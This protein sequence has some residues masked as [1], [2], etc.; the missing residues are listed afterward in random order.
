MA[1]LIL[2]ITLP[3]GKKKTIRADE[4]KALFFGRDPQCDVQLN[5]PSVGPVHFRIRRAGAAWVMETATNATPV[6]LNGEPTQRAELLPGDQLRVGNVLIVVGEPEA[7]AQRPAAAAAARLA[8]PPADTFAAPPQA[9]PA[10]RPAAPIAPPSESILRS[11]LI[12]GSAVALVVLIG[13]G[14]YLYVW[15]YG[16]TSE[17]LFDQAQQAMNE[18][19]SVYARKL[20]ERFLEEY[21]D[22]EL[23]N[24][25]LIYRE[26]CDVQAAQNEGNPQEALREL[27]DLFERT[28]KLPEFSDMAAEVA[29]TAVRVALQL[30]EAAQTTGRR[31]DYEQARE[32]FNVLRE[33]VPED[34]QPEEQIQQLE[35]A[36][37]AAERAVIK[38]ERY[39][40][41]IATM[42]QALKDRDT[43]RAYR[44]RDELVVLYPDFQADEKLQEL[45]K[46]GQQLD[47]DR[48]R[49]ET[50]QLTP[51]REDRQ[52][53]AGVIAATPVAGAGQGPS[54]VGYQLA[55]G[56]LYAVST[57]DGKPLWRRS[58]GP[59]ARHLPVEL[60]SSVGARI[61]VLAPAHRELAVLDATSGKLQWRI[62]FDEPLDAP[63]IVHRDKL[64]LV[65][66]AGN[67]YRIDPGTGRVEGRL[68]FG[69]QELTVPPV[70]SVSGRH[71]YVVGEHSNVYIV[72]VTPRQ[73][74]AVGIF[75]L[76]HLKKTVHAAP[77]RMGRYLI[78]CENR[79]PRDCVLRVLL[80]AADERAFEELPQD[81]RL[82]GWVLS[83]PASYGNLIYV[84]TDRDTV[85]LFSAGAP[86]RKEGLKRLAA[87]RPSAV[88]EPSGPAYAVF[89][90]EE[91]LIVA[92]GTVRH[93]RVSLER[94][95]LRPTS[96]VDDIS[97]VTVQPVQKL[98]DQVFLIGWKANEDPAFRLT[99]VRFTGQTF[100]KLWE[101]RFALGTTALRS[102]G[103]SD[104]F[105]VT[106]TADLFRLTP[107]SDGVDFLM[108]PVGRV[109]LD[110]KVLRTAHAVRLPDGPVVYVPQWGATELYVRDDVDQTD[111]RRL[112]LPAGIACAPCGF[113]G[114][115]LLPATDQRVYLLDV[116]DGA[117]L[118]EPFQPPVQFDVERQW[119]LVLPI[120]KTSALA[121]DQTGAVFILK[122]QEEQRQGGTVRYVAAAAETNVPDP[123]RPPAVLIGGQMLAYI[124]D[125]GEVV[126]AELPLL[127][128]RHRYPVGAQAEQMSLTA[129]ED[130]IVVADRRGRL[131][132]FRA[133]GE[134][135]WEQDI[136]RALAGTPVAVKGQLFCPLADGV[137]A[138]V[139]LADGQVVHQVD[140]H[141]PLAGDP[142]VA[143]GAL[144]VPAYDGTI[145]ALHLTGQ[146]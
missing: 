137:V 58:L 77:L 12:I 134:K 106:A 26:L 21:P 52:Q 92:G 124:T 95:T 84:A 101:T 9:P 48:C 33:R 119:Q 90:N 37:A 104:A 41:T 98:T 140:L 13:L 56:I 74:E 112:V 46:Q 69:D 11:P 135:R 53:P 2:Q 141:E 63:P 73:L 61:A 103:G 85:Y 24:Q 60:P 81:L 50:V 107:G 99:A 19:R 72:A 109:K 51:V 94:Q 122:V 121:A 118:A 66:R 120:D 125:G 32:A 117:E 68:S 27:V 6:E 105:L 8:R 36:L 80:A 142:A 38:K 67:L 127:N 64:Y 146:P 35:Q 143:G 110:P 91:N 139:S 22:H 17:A 18:G 34:K 15:Y 89:V 136:G 54:G 116:S 133:T 3:G 45:L 115:L 65:T 129:I 144:L 23:A 145:H 57:R 20:F 78:V 4:S 70:P 30:A 131:F 87:A 42:E 14:I 28:S 102:K 88:V 40:N 86:E 29:D 16:R 75:Y 5:D 39:D 123:L 44:A 1:T 96:I 111:V 55:Q 138:V 10:T 25:A 7:M 113:A 49:W 82:P 31:S 62:V 108:T 71:L 100:E 97:G 83:T 114:G 93:Y 59:D 126:F 130:G 76:G 128:E 43:E 47:L 132:C 79:Q